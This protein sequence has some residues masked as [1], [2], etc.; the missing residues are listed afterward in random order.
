MPVGKLDQLGDAVRK[1]IQPVNVLSAFDGIGGAHA[2][3]DRAGVP[4]GRRYVSE[5]DPYAA[6]VVR[7][8]YPDA[9][10]VGDI[11]NVSKATVPD[12]IDLMCGGFPC[13]DLSRGN[14]AG[15]GLEG[16][17][18][19]LFW[20]F[21]RARDEIKPKHFLVENVVPR[22]QQG[23]RDVRTISS[24]LGVDP[25]FLDAEDFGPMKRPRLWWTDLPVGM[26]SQS[27]AVFRDALSPQVD[28]RYL[29]SDAAREYMLRPAGKS[30]RTHFQ[31]HGYDIN[32]PKARTVPRVIHKGIPYNAVRL[33]DGSMRKLTPEELES[34]FGFPEGYT[35]GL[36]DSRR[37]MGLGNS[38]SVPT[39]TH[40]LR[41]LLE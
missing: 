2:A 17:R 1:L 36:S 8:N 39:A 12:E 29:L 14:V 4:V 30:G 9:I 6:S 24:A 22:G 35:S 40:I 23:E 5:I 25:V 33:D 38:W 32:D 19:G 28:A 21:V 27:T 7:K 34:M 26:H 3:L 31:R 20:E 16:D 11:R 41:G 13:Q 18:S 15:K 10:E 37:Y